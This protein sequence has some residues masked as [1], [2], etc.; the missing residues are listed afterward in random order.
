MSDSNTI[1]STPASLPPTTPNFPFSPTAITSQYNITQSPFCSNSHQMYQPGYSG[2]QDWGMGH[3][4]FSPV[5]YHYPSP[6]L[7]Q[8]VSLLG[9]PPQ[10]QPPSPFILCFISGN[11]STCFGC[12]T[13]YSKSL[14]PP[15]D[16][17]IRHQDWREFY[18]EKT[19]SMQIKYGNVYYH[20]KPEC[21][22][23]HCP[24]FVPS[25]LQV[26]PETLDKLTP[27]HKSHIRSIFGLHL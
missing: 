8:S 2:N 18:S 13:R 26:P 22:W 23:L 5:L 12:K 16:L 3:S 11:I 15:A 7:S 27:I 9:S 24:F 14:T 1:S 20:C 6:A 21:V 17:C 19:E 10:Y 25:Q 4:T